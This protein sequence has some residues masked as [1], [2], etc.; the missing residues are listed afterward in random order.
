[1]SDEVE[2][3]LHLPSDS[4]AID[5]IARISAALGAQVAG[6]PEGSARVQSDGLLVYGVEPDG[7]DRELARSLFDLDTNLTL[8]FVNLSHGDTEMKIRVEQNIM[9]IM[10]LLA[11]VKGSRGIY[12]EDYSPDA[13]VLRFESG[14]LTLNQ[15]WEGWQLWPEV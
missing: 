5:A 6:G 9:R 2:L 13:I 8:V 7:D 4:P 15:D 1:M 3:L 14:Q 12:V 11:A 10:L